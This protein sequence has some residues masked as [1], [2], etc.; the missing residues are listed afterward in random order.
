MTDEISN[1]IK[2]IKFK[3]IEIN[4]RLKAELSKNNLLETEIQNIKYSFE[5]QNKLT[6]SLENEIDNLKK[7]ILI[8][9]E[10]NKQDSNI[11]NKD[12]EIDLL[13]REIDYCIQ[14]LK[15]N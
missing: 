4:D 9:S 14:Q 10:K 8:L 7:E 2:Q 1:I 6:R 11:Q 3:F 15:G 12:H 13:V 5:G